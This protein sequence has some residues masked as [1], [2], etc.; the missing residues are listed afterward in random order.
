MDESGSPSD[1]G[2]KLNRV[3]RFDHRDIGWP[4]Y[5]LNISWLMT[6]AVSGGLLAVFVT[7]PL[8]QGVLE[9]L[10]SNFR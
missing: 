5:L 6:T 8:V 4:K 2:E 1:R 9:L 7:R 3:N 10:E